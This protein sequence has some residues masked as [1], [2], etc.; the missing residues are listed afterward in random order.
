[1]YSLFVSEFVQRIEFDIHA[2]CCM[3]QQLM[4]LF[5]EW[6]SIVW[7]HHSLSFAC[8]YTLNIVL[9]AFGCSRHCCEYL[10]KRLGKD[11]CFYFSQVNTQEWVLWAVDVQHF[12]NLPNCFPEWLHRS[13]VFTN[14]VWECYILHM[15]SAFVSFSFCLADLAFLLWGLMV[16]KSFSV[17]NV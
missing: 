3:H 14:S 17:F 10:Q 7:K 4:T 15:V 5:A 13:A 9:S 6:C 12:K 1:M 2:C 11:I 8:H 16:I